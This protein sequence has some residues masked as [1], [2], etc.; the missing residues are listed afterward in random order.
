[1]RD[2]PWLTAERAR[3]WCTALGVAMLAGVAILVGTTRGGIAMNGMPVA[4]DFLSFWAA[5]DLLLAGRPADAYRPEPHIAV[6][7][8]LFPGIAGYFAF[9]YPPVFLLLCAPLALLPYGASVA[10]WL[11]VTGGAYAAATRALLPR[12]G[13]LPVLAFPAGLINIRYGQNGFL[14]AALFA[15]AAALLE[16]RPVLAGIALGGLAYKPHLAIA[17]PFVLAA[18]GR[19]RAFFAC[20]ATAAALAALSWAVL[21]SDTWAAFREGSALAR[22]ALEEGWVSPEKMISLFAGVRLMG[23]SLA[24][25]WGLQGVLTASVLVLAMLAARRRPGGTAEVAV[26][27]AAAMLVSPFL[28]DYDLVVTAVPLAWLLLA[29][30]CAGFLPWEKLLLVL[31]YIWPLAARMAVEATRLPLA[32]LAGLVLFAL[33]LRRLRAAAP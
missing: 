11:A 13:W 30:I 29:G 15:A 2:A 31:L 25:A 3:L 23:G 10:A 26:I 5:S 20:G 27:A 24:L 12:W 22:R 16:K 21:G 28:L 6:Q 9:F 17:V 14:S 7:A 19:W 33:A 18:A 8:A 4:G 1:M 32:V